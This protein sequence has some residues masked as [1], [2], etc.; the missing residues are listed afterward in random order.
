MSI[1]QILIEQN[2]TQN[3]SKLIKSLNIGSSFLIVSDENT[4]QIQ[5]NK[6]AKLLNCSEVTFK[7]N[8]DA[9]ISIVKKIQEQSRDID[10]I[11][12]VGSG[13]IN[14]LCKYASYLEKK[15]YVVFGTAPS[16]NGY[17]SSNASITVDGYKS[18][19]KAHLPSAI[20]LDLEI[21]ADAPI[22]LIKSGLGDS[23]CRSTAQADWL[24]SHFILN[25]NYNKQAFD[26]LKKSEDKLFSNANLLIKR[27]IP[28][29]RLLAENLILSGMGMNICGGS[30]PASQAEHMIA[31]TIHM[32]YVNKKPSTYH[33]EEIAVTTISMAKLQEHILTEQSAPNLLFVDIKQVED[34]LNSFFK[35]EFIAKNC[36][37]SFK[38][39]Y[40]NK[41]KTNNINLNIKKNWQNWR[42]QILENF[43]TSGKLIKVL[44]QSEISFK[45]SKFDMSDIDYDKC[46]NIAR[47]TRDRFTFLDV[48]NN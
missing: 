13:T 34:E 32:K 33:G 30:Y 35:D 24:L 14:D 26:M 1:K 29:I 42:K 16:M 6:I 23:L 47:F 45:A 12:A 31:H 18:T 9:E 36:L 3:A 25:S 21:L 17:A 11:I 43:L 46:I 22:R 41:E 44:Q 2:I 38:S 19:L 10:A 20:F 28:T 48:K 4:Y 5:A 27:D 40:F 39:K 37:E 7:K 15:P 8:I